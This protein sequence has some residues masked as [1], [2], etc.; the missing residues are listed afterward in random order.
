MIEELKAVDKN[1]KSIVCDEDSVIEIRF[2][3]DKLNLLIAIFSSTLENE[4]E[5]YKA[6]IDFQ[7]K[8]LSVCPIDFIDTTL[9]FTTRVLTGKK[10][11]IKKIEITKDEIDKIKDSFF[12]MNFYSKV[13][14]NVFDD[15]T[16]DYIYKKFNFYNDIFS[17]NIDK[18]KN[19][20]NIHLISDLE[21]ITIY[22]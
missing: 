14:S 4:E 8:Y 22:L 11:D 16:Y 12:K 6:F 19:Y 13:L 2:L 15:K 20:K 9:S 17:N 10:I 18:Y 1:K 7:N 21:Y 5:A 3:H